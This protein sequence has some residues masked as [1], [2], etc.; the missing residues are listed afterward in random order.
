MRMLSVSPWPDEQAL[1][2]FALIECIADED[3]AEAQG[4]LADFLDAFPQFMAPLW[5]GPAV[6]QAASG[7][8][9]DYMATVREWFATR[10][11]VWFN[12]QGV[13]LPEDLADLDRVGVFA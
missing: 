3:D 12:T 6:D 9:Q 8:P 13:W 2:L 11:L 7:V 4:I 10:L 5:L 1:D